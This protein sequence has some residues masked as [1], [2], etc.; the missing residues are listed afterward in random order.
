M[1]R[2]LYLFFLRLYCQFFSKSEVLQLYRGESKYQPYKVEFDCRENSLIMSSHKGFMGGMYISSGIPINSPFYLS[3]FYVQHPQSVLFLGGG[4]C[5]DAISLHSRNSEINITIVERDLLT[6]KL[7]KKYFGLPNANNISVHIKDAGE[8][9]K[10]N[11]NKYD[12]IFFDL[13][14][15]YIRR[16]LRS[17]QFCQKIT[18][19]KRIKNMLT[20]NG[21]L[22]FVVISSRKGVQKKFLN[23]LKI[24]F[25]EV[26]PIVDL[27]CDKPKENKTIQSHIFILANKRLKNRH[28]N[29]LLRQNGLWG[30]YY[31]ELIKKRFNSDNLVES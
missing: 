26:F 3:D 10:E 20:S 5:C 23:G 21:T 28:R 12:V 18:F 22:V 7:A 14:F 6:V 24:K 8:Y 1:F 11:T 15:A 31:R 9:I 16:N 30:N 19:L 2:N 4:P 17:F 29:I 13:G 27:Y 25:E